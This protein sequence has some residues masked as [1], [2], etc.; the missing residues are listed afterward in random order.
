MFDIYH[1]YKI[2][3]EVIIIDKKAN[4]HPRNRNIGEKLIVVETNLNSK[5][6]RVRF[7]GDR[8]AGNDF[9]WLSTKYIMPVSEYNIIKRDSYLGIILIEELKFY[10]DEKRH[11]VCLP[12]SIDNLHKMADILELKRCWFHKDHYD[13]PKRRIEEI[14]N[15][16]TKVSSKDIVNI[17]NGVLVEFTELPE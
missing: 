1:K 16:S 9:W 2:G 10:W 7:S 14:S 11:L 6:P 15:K 8:Y 12:Y 3:D 17:I 13:I 5:C 4:G